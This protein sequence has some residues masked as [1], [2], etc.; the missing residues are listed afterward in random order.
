MQRRGIRN[1]ARERT[2]G[3][4]PETG[5]NLMPSLCKIERLHR[6]IERLLEAP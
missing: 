5:R 3:A 1:D 4:R 6:K 2:V